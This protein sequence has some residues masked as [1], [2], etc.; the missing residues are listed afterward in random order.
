LAFRWCFTEPSYR[1]FVALLAGMVAQPGRRTVCGM[2]T[3]AGLARFWHHSRAHWFFSH[4]RWSAEQVGLV[5][6]GLIVAGL[7]PA[8]A[9]VLVAV[10][11]TLMRRSGRRVAGA[12]WQHDG[13]RKGPKGSQVSWGTC[14]V[15][16]G[17]VVTLPFLDRPV[18]LPVLARLWRPR[19]TSKA[20]L[21]CQMG[22]IAVA[23]QVFNLQADHGAFN[24]R[25]L[26]WVLQP[27][28]A[29]SQ[30]GMQPI[31]AGRGCLAVAGGFGGRHVLGLGPCGWLGQREL[32]T[33]LGWPAVG[34]G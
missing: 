17:I 14:F 32:V 3:G 9:P 15:V 13:A 24:D 16:A 18:C 21:A 12:A 25:Q 2:L 31:P 6:V 27:A 26:A 33:V 22:R 30:P 8:G 4:A 1:T 10:D 29:V 11:D 23:G 7:L 34:S 5:L 19:G 28:G 20:V